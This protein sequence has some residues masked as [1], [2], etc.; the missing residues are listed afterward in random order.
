MTKEKFIKLIKMHQ[1]QNNDLDA[2]EKFIA[3]DSPIIEFG[4]FMFEFLMEEVFCE[5]AR[6]T[7]Y[8]WLYEYDEDHK[9]YNCDGNEIPMNTI[10]DLWEFLQSN[11]ALSSK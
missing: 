10:D 11:Y 4:W 6:D 5:E 9:M 3:I 8:W 1:Q 2:V 7:I